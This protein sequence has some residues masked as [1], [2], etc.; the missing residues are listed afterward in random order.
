MQTNWLLSSKQWLAGAATGLGLLAAPTAWAQVPAAPTVVATVDELL[1]KPLGVRYYDHY[2]VP[3]PG[4]AGAAG[5]EVLRRIDSVGLNWQVRRY[6]AT[7]RQLV[8]EQFFTGSVPGVV[9]EGPSREWYPGGELREEVSYHKGRIVGTLRTFYRNGRPR[10]TQSMRPSATACYDSAGRVLATCPEYHT[11]A[12]LRG[13]KTDSGRFLQLVQQQFPA[14]LPPGYR[15]H[16]AQTV[17]YAFRIDPAGT[18]RDA[19]L[20]TAAAPELEGAILRAIAQ[21]PAFEPAQLEGQ[22]TND[23]VEGAVL[24]KP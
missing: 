10:R 8:L 3:L 24:V 1:N 13:K 4:A 12:R 11:F 21:L 14:L 5:Y 17:Y 6:V 19:R 15:P 2:W 16:V 23:I 9:F 22:P 7:P 18:V 20:L